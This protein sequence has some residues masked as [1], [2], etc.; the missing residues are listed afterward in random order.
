MITAETATLAVC[1][2]QPLTN[3][4][5]ETMTNATPKYSPDGRGAWVLTYEDGNRPYTE[6][7][8]FEGAAR[9]YMRILS[10]DFTNV[11]LE[12]GQQGA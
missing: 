4:E 8:Y 5:N 6:R 7:F 10:D 3:T 12:L 1:G 2:N 11:Y 9:E